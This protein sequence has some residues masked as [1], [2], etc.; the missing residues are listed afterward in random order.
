[1]VRRADGTLEEIGRHGMLLAIDD[2][3]EFSEAKARLEPGDTL[4]LYTDGLIDRD[5]LGFST[6]RLASILSSG[7][8]DVDEI[9]RTVERDVDAMS[10]DERTDDVAVLAVGLPSAEP[11][12]D[13]SDA[14]PGE[15]EAQP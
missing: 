4:V 8:R 14:P 1:V 2:D 6:G 11:T 7:V 9:V 3:A 12:V 13:P 15:V 5:E 10:E